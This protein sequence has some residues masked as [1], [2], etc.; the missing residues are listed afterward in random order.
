MFIAL[1]F[2]SIAGN[3]FAQKFE[4]TLSYKIYYIP[5]SKMVK[6][7]DLEIQYGNREIV[8]IRN[9]YYKTLRQYGD[10]V[11]KTSVYDNTNHINYIQPKQAD[12]WIKDQVSS[13]ISKRLVKLDTNAVIGLYPCSVYRFVKTALKAT[14]FVSKEKYAGKNPDNSWFTYPTLF[15]GPVV[16]LVVEYPDYTMV[17][18]LS[19][20]E[21]KTLDNKEFETGDAMIVI[22]ADDITNNT[23]EPT[24]RR[25]L[26]Q[27]LYKS[28][29]Y[30]GFLQFSNTEG[31][32]AVEL[33]LDQAGEL[34]NINIRTEYFKKQEESIRIYNTQKIRSL[35]HKTQGKVL[36]LVKQCM[37]G[38][39]FEAPLSGGVKVNTLFRIPFT[40]SKN[41]ADVAEENQDM[42]EQDIDDAFYDDFEEFY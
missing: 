26:L 40:F 6:T 14:F 37:T 34:K 7:S 33:L 27:C 41:A 18:E 28:I 12:Y 16:K 35:E 10:Q 4:G 42:D 25:E 30:P 3:G 13:D 17:Q 1:Y 15:Q 8:S 31:K 21:A 19:K 9:G 32:I 29:G 20:V 36:P 23:L 24:Q 22:P 5:G 39:K 2:A 38:Y 11:L